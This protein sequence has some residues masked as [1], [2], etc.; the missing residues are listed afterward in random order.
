METVSYLCYT[1][2]RKDRA[3][4]LHIA[5]N[6]TKEEVQGYLYELFRIIDRGIEPSECRNVFTEEPLCI[7]RL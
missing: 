2:G 4:V 1:K 5:A 3:A 6:A 7:H